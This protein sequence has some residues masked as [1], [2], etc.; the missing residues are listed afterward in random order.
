MPDEMPDDAIKPITKFERSED[1]AS[2]Y[3]NHV[4]FATSV[5]DIRVMFGEI[6]QFP[7][8]PPFV[9]QHTSMTLSWRE[10]KIAALFLAMNV[11]MHEN[12]FGTL[13]IP[14]GILPPKFQRTA[15]EGKLP[16]TKLLEFLEHRPPVKPETPPTE[17]TQ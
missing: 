9:N 11:A 8:I 12:K 10:A 3:A 6:L 1:F 15:E 13:D 4:Y 16:L 7:D 14:D 17:T 5:F 2:R